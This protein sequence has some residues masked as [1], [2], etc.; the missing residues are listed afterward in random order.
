MSR[1]AIG[2]AN[3][4]GQAHAWAQAVN[5]HLPA[6]AWS[7][8]SLPLRGGS[9][10]NFGTDHTIQGWRDRNPVAR[11]LRSRVLFRGTTHIAL[12]GFRTYYRAYQRGKFG[13]DA[14]WLADHGWQ[15]AVISHGTDARDP[16]R[17]MDRLEASYFR[18]GS[19]EWRS[20]LSAS[21]SENRRTAEEL[22]MPVFYSTPDLALDLPHGTWLP[23]AVDIDHWACDQPVLE[24]RVPRVVHVPSHSV[25]KGTAY[26]SAVMEDLASRGVIEYISPAKMPH[27]QMK[28]VIQSADV[29]IDQVLTGFYGVAAVEAMAA[30]RVL[31]GSLADDVAALMPEAPQF[32]RADPSTLKDV[33]LSVLDRRDEMRAAVA[34]NLAFVRR[35]HDGAESARRLG[36]FLG[37]EA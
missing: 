4:A 22:G 7:F 12:D 2:P 30:G 13:G 27:A 37:V 34:D 8:T 16:Q 18:D 26:I 29:V 23:V 31:I 6:T 10:F 5:R 21:A 1:L 15:V 20:A 25:V 11:G 28:A 9:I 35:W 36:P 32:L 14:R 24:R 3:H 19:P 33:M 17:H